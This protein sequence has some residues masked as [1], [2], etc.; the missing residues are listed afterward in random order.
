MMILAGAT[1]RGATEYVW[2]EGK[3]AQV[4][5]AKANVAGWGH[6]EF[7]SGEKWLHVF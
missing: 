6:K 2:L 7:L 3:D 1:A 5:G 4:Q